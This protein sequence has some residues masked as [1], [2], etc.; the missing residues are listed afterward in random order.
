MKNELFY[1]CVEISQCE[2]KQFVQLICT[3]KKLLRNNIAAPNHLFL[4][5]KITKLTNLNCTF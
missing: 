5:I 2:T 3:N 1:T 4:K